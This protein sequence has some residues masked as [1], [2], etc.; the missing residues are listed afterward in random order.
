MSEEKKDNSKL[1]QDL[2]LKEPLYI[3]TDRL[4]EIT[5]EI[6]KYSDPDTDITKEEYLKVSSL[7][8]EVRNMEFDTIEMRNEIFLQN[9]LFFTQHFY[10]KVNRNYS[11]ICKDLD[12][13]RLI[14]EDAKF[15]YIKDI[16]KLKGNVDLFKYTHI[17]EIQND[18]ERKTN[19]DIKKKSIEALLSE[20]YK[21]RFKIRKINELYAMKH[22]KA[23]KNKS[24][25]E[26]FKTLLNNLRNK[27][28]EYKKSLPS[29]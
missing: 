9:I 4:I 22:N 18:I 2:Y 11:D 3:H 17:L 15:N 23:N 20:A 27:Y 6:V 12:I 29:S 26:L 1:L 25:D 8:D 7:L 5:E 21:T 13:Q 16:Q 28:R 14:E 19:N 10:L 24:D